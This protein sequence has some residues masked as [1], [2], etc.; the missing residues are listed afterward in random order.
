[1][2]KPDTA[3]RLALQDLIADYAWALDTGD[4]DALVRCFTEDAALVDV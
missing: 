4:A 2:A 3:T 1:M